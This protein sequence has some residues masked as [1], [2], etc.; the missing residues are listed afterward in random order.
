MYNYNESLYYTCSLIE[1]IA[2][3]TKNKCKDIINYLGKD[4][5]L[6]YE[7]QDVYHCEPIEKVAD[8]FITKNKIKTGSFDNINQSQ[9]EIPSYWRI[10]KIFQRLIEDCYDGIDIFVAIREVYNSWFAEEIFDFNTDLYYQP[11][12]Y[13]AE[14]YK[15]GKILED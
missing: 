7:F 8:D 9:Y 15:A 6:I 2:R 1:Y 11:R 10:G 13:L 3:E 5:E 4:L 14:C 12:D